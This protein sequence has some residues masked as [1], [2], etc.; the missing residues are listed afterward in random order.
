MLAA[1]TSHDIGGGDACCVAHI[2]RQ[3]VG[4]RRNKQ[5]DLVTFLESH[6]VSMDRL[7][8][9]R[10]LV[11]VVHGGTFTDA[12]KRLKV[13]PA[14]ITSHIKSLEARLGIQLLS[15]TTRKV[16]L[17]EAGRMYYERCTHILA[18]VDEAESIVSALQAMPSGTLR[19]NTSV[20]LARLVAP[21]I[22]EYVKLYPHV[23][24]D[25]VMTDRM[26]DL[27]DGEFDLALRAGP[28]PD[29]SL[30]SRRIGLGR[31]VLCASPAYIAEH[32]APARPANLDRH[33]CLL[34]LNSF[35]DRGWRFSG[36]DAEEEIT[37]TGN[38]RT[39]SVEA[40]RTAALSG[41]GIALLPA[42]I[43]AD[44]LRMG[45]LI[46]L[47]PEFRTNEAIIQA[48]YPPSRHLSAKART[49]IDFLT[50]RL[51]EDPDWVSHPLAAVGKTGRTQSQL[52]V[53]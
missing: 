24:F 5:F 13:S 9:M 32:G 39:N 42:T 11:E 47:L 19:V 14:R 51:R 23:A 2:P 37:A 10:A 25:L 8:N 28:L 45:S 50:S 18:E 36:V 4:T 31:L 38:F 52:C 16:N 6:E 44:D 33:N 22:T 40:L 41:H 35:P 17:T 48:L 21:L 26:A 27:V 15:R 46:Q 34:S 49:F 1:H 12:A 3:S 30:I 43:I 20:T 7:M 29:S 53:S